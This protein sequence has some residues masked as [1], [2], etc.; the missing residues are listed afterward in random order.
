MQSALT[1]SETFPLIDTLIRLFEAG[2]PAIMTMIS[3]N[4]DFR[5]D[6]YNDDADVSWQQASNLQEFGGVLT[7]LATDIFPKGTKI[8]ALESESLDDGWVTTRFRQQFF[9]G[10]MQ[11]MVE[12]AT[13]ILSHETDGK[14]DFFRETVLTVEKI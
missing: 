11:Q 7:R 1:Q 13:V 8:I 9:Y 5:I 2:D 6:H 3:N 14:I 4:I 10:L 12:S